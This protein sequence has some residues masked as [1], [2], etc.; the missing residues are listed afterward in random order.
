MIDGTSFA[1]VGTV[2]SWVVEHVH[3]LFLA[4]PFR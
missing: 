2:R 1:V 4:D 3:F